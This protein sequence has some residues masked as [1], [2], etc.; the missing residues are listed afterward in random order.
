MKRLAK[1]TTQM[2]REEDVFARYGGEEFVVL[3]RGVAIPGAA[4]AGER[5]RKAVEAAPTD[6]DGTIIR[7]TVSVGCASLAC[8]ERLDPEALV[9]V[10]DRRL[11]AAKHAGRNRVASSG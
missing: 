6:A 7:S 8:A 4:R 11:Y 1:I 2:L 3:L 10:A 5:L 9:G